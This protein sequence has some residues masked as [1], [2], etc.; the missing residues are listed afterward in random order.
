MAAVGFDLYSRLLA[1]AVEE[2]KARLRG[3]RAGRRAAAGRDR[4]AGR[5][6]PARRLRARRGPEARAVPAAR[7]GPRRRATSPRS[8]RSSPTGSA[9]CPQPVLRL[10]EVAELRLAAEAAGVASIVP[11]GGQ[12]VVRFGAGLSR[13][14]AMRLLGGSAALP[15]VRPGDLT[16]ASNQVRIRLP[17]DPSRVVGADPGGRRPPLDRRAR[18][19]PRRRLRIRRSRLAMPAGSRVD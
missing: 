16:F 9:R 2:R 19:G 3:P 6:P 15:G 4:P 1:E 17:R 5:G 18:G 10:V 8:A 12:L 7:P 11:R 13:A 14:T